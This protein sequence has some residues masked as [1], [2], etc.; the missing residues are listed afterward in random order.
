[1][2]GT[3][4]TT[5]GG[6]TGVAGAIKSLTSAIGVP[7]VPST[8]TVNHYTTYTYNGLIYTAGTLV[9]P[10][11]AGTTLNPT[12]LNPA[13]VYV[14]VGT[15]DLNGNVTINGTLVVRGTLRVK[16]AGNVINP[17]SGFPAAVIDSNIS[18]NANNSVLTANG[19]T[20]LGGVVNRTLGWTGCSLSVNGGLLLAGPAPTID[21]NVVVQVNFDNK[22]T[23]VSTL[24]DPTKTAPA[25]VTIVSWKNQ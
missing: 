18:F 19:L 23:A 8:L 3:I 25:S 5:S 4:Y 1:V 10:P 24:A 14:Y 12:P 16:N 21:S 22:K 2:T 9:L 11:A 15:L 7:V 6:G 13:G 20:Y 17:Q